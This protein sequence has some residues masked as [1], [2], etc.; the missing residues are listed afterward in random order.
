MVKSS[1]SSK[2][3]LVENKLLGNDAVAEQVNGN[4]MTVCRYKINEKVSV[5]LH[6]HEYEQIIYVVQGQMNLTVEEKQISMKAGDIQVILSNEKHG[7]QITGVPFQVIES[8]YPIRSDLLDKQ[9]E[10]S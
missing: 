4:N 3:N 1:K 9:E 5:P 6:S 8:Y 7:S 2:W 10:C